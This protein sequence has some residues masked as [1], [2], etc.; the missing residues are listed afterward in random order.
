[1]AEKSPLKSKKFIAY[2]LAEIT[3]KIVLI[4]ALW[5]GK[6]VMLARTDLEGGAP[7]MWWFM[8][9]VVIV[10][11]FIEA[12]F[13]GGQAWLDKYVRVAKITSAVGGSNASTD[14]ATDD[15]GGA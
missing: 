10:A 4:S 12:G 7:G 2:L 3:W 15:S 1:M 5:G 9:T 8:F 6:D 13:I 11:G 14:D